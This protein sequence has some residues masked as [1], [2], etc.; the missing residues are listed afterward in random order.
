MKNFN[1]DDELEKLEGMTIQEKLSA[2]DVLLDR[3]DH[4]FRKVIDESTEDDDEETSALEDELYDA[5]EEVI[6]AKDRVNNKYE[7]SCR[8][9]FAKKIEA[10][11]Q[12]NHLKGITPDKYGY[13][14]TY[15]RKGVAIRLNW[16]Q[17]YWAIWFEGTS[18]GDMNN[19]SELAI[20]LGTKLTPEDSNSCFE[21]DTNEEEVVPK[22]LKALNLSDDSQQ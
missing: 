1:I 2:L 16:C 10:Y 20:K 15:N 22:I 4:E 11:I 21:I 19:L 8:K 13:K 12:D 9:R 5:I 3:L 14:M 7:T 6:N 18:L 17:E